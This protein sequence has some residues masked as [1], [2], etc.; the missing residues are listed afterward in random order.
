MGYIKKR[1]MRIERKIYK[2]TYVYDGTGFD[3]IPNKSIDKPQILYKLYGLN[4]YSIDSLINKYVYATH[5]S[6]LNDIFDCN[7]ELLD[8]DDVE[9]VRI[10]LK[11]S[12]SDE[13]LNLLIKQ[14]FDDLKIFTQR[15]F[16]EKIYRKWGVFSM[17]GNPNN[18]LMW[19]Y[20][21]NNKGYCIEFDINKFPFKFYGPFPINYQPKL[22]ALSIKKIGVQI[23]TIAQCNLKDEIWKH[24]NEW[25]LMIVATNGQDMF[26]P[27]F[28]M[29][30][31]FG[32]HD[33]KFQYPLT[34]IKSIALGNR[35]F[36]PEEIRKINDMKLEINLKSNI[37]QKSKILNFLSTNNIKT[38]IG[39]R[40]GFTEII[41]RTSTIETINK[42]KY[43]INAY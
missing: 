13:E 30:K 12:M 9:S 39:L 18:I 14:N 16:R 37:E 25:R 42:N 36:D 4:E 32:G 7:E 24:E 19:S 10:F 3:V 41:F 22:D 26:S 17:T 27:N 31:K 20:Y 23:G 2:W 43:K 38:H 28:E 21:G 15:H 6:Q 40:K 1:H 33:R 11:D 5:P 8:F 35:F 34:A 29:L